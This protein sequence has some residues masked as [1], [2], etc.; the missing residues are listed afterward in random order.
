VRRTVGRA[1][2]TEADARRRIAAQWPL[3]EKVRR[4][5]FVV[6][7]DGTLDETRRQARATYEALVRRASMK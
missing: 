3:A 6:R 7:T 2:A 5:D 1:G 4:A